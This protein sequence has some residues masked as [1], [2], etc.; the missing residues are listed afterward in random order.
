MVVGWKQYNN[1]F[2]EFKYSYEE[3]TEAVLR[4]VNDGMSVRESAKILGAWI[5]KNRDV[6]FYLKKKKRKCLI[7]IS[8]SK[9]RWLNRI[10]R[11]CGCIETKNFRIYNWIE[12][13]NRKHPFAIKIDNKGCFFANN[14][15]LPKG[16]NSAIF[17]L[18]YDKKGPKITICYRKSVFWRVIWNI[19]QSHMLQIRDTAM[20]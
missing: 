8:I 4:I 9:L 17:G 6:F 11:I 18:K 7:I 16:R 1:I 14:F 15:R 2:M 5:I 10:C 19:Q 13:R 12:Q 3:K 20:H